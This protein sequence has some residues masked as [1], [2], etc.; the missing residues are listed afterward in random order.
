MT[1]AQLTVD[2]V[3]LAV[4][5]CDHDGCDRRVA[6]AAAMGWWEWPRPGRPLLTWCPDHPPSGRPDIRRD[7][8]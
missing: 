6:A 1:Y 4:I 8:P 2:G 3:L 5:T 7:T